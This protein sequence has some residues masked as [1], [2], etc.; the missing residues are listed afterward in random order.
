[1]SSLGDPDIRPD[2]IVEQVKQK[3]AFDRMRKYLLADFQEHVCMTGCH[4]CQ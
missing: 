1:M 2:D 4:Y 3:G